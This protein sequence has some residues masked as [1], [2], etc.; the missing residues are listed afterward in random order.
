MRAYSPSATASCTWSSWNVVFFSRSGSASTPCCSTVRCAASDREPLGLGLRELP[1]QV[2]ELL[3]DDVLLLLVGVE[4]ALPPAELVQ[5]RFGRAQTL[6][7]LAEPRVQ[8]VEARLVERGA[9]AEPCRRNASTCAFAIRAA[10]A[11]SVDANVTLMRRV[12]G[13]ASTS[14]APR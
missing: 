14:I 13:T 1:V 2:V 8:E 7:Q 11:G 12:P 6:L 9:L 5:R 3:D 10:N 4:D